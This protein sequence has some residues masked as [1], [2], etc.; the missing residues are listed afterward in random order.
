MKSPFEV[1]LETHTEP[2]FR[3]IP[4][5]TRT[6]SYAPNVSWKYLP[7]QLK[8]HIEDYGLDI[9]PDFQRGHVWDDEKRIHYVEF[10]LRGGRSS[11]DLYFNCPDCHI[12][13]VE[14]YVLVDG[15]QRLAAAVKFINNEIPAFGHYFREFIDKMP[16]MEPNFLWHVNDLK[17]REE[18]L[19]WY[20][21]LNS[22]GVVHTSEELNRV[23]KL[24]KEEQEKNH[25]S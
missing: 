24:L 5:F 1:W 20:L 10:A 11:M 23:R 15:K 4:Q 12:G 8:H 22:G 9:N 14:D 13:G 6:G 21:E 17:T 16:M 25:G 19:T 2:R 3:D 7:E 18:V